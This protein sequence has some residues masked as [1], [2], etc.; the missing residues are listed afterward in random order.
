MTNKENHSR[1][2]N[3]L[4]K[5]LE[6]ETEANELII[7][8]VIADFTEAASGYTA[9]GELVAENAGLYI[10]SVGEK[11]AVEAFAEIWNTEI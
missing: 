9:I 3:A 10:D 1:I 5:V 11:A 6:N 2:L 8:M 7:D 4:M